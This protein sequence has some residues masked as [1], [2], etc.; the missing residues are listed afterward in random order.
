MFPASN[1]SLLIF[2][3]F[4]FFTHNFAQSHFIQIIHDKGHL[5]FIVKGV[6]I[7]FLCKNTQCE[8]IVEFKVNF[9]QTFNCFFS[10]FHAAEIKSEYIFR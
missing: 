10:E 2:F 8:M 5:D 9:N 1:M 6:N 3:V 7:S 4:F